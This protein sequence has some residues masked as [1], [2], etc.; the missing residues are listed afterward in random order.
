MSQS[1]RLTTIL[2]FCLCLSI[3]SKAM[4]LNWGSWTIGERLIYRCC[5]NIFQNS[6]KIHL[7]CRDTSRR[8]W[9]ILKLTKFYSI[10]LR[11]SKHWLCP[12]V[13]SSHISYYNTQESQLVLHINWFGWRRCRASRRETLTTNLRGCLALNS[14]WASCSSWRKNW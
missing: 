8:Y 3:N 4:L 14:T 13:K 12:L 6:T 9:R 10:C 7:L 11:F 1:I 2:L 5:L